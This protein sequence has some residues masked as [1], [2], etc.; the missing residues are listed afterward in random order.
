[1]VSF[2]KVLELLPEIAVVETGEVPPILDGD[3]LYLVC[4]DAVGGC[5]DATHDWFRCE[6]GA[7]VFARGNPV[8]M[9]LRSLFTHPVVFAGA[10]PRRG[11]CTLETVDALG[12][13]DVCLHD[14]L[15]DEEI[16]GFL[17]PHAEAVDV[18]KRCGRHKVAQSTINE[19]LLRHAR[20][21]K[22]V[23]RLK[24][25]DPG[26]YGRLFEETRELSVRELP[27]RV[28]PAV[29][30]LTVATTGTGFLLT[31]RGSHRGFVVMTPR[32]GGGGLGEIDPEDRDLPIVLF[33]A[34]HVIRETFDRLRRRGMPGSTPA[35]VVYEAG[36]RKEEVLK[37][38]V[39]T[40]PDLVERERIRTGI[41]L[42]GRAC[43]MWPWPRF[44]PFAGRSVVVAP[45]SAQQFGRAIEEMDGVVV[46]D[47]QGRWIG[48]E[49]ELRDL[50]VA[51]V[52]AD[53][54]KLRREAYA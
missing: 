13:A 7:V 46:S 50:A 43:A 40:L 32:T 27:F 31:C 51:R 10:P 18:G 25:G 19:M 17:P 38:T 23:V 35:A 6:A 2:A 24:A 22:R 4:E 49:T 21:G 53:I 45:S 14:V 8:G 44:G 12:C 30:S 16:L 52:V 29:S 26:V 28:Q 34:V 15:F 39:E 36:T 1:M 37:G 11:L 42:V 33:M 3:T 48:D 5:R 41:V 47:E 20:E 54:R 9:R